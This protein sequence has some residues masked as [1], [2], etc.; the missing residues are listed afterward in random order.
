M[1][2]YTDGNIAVT[3][4]TGEIAA[5]TPVLA[6]IADGNEL[7]ITATGAAAVSEAKQLSQLKGAFAQTEVADDEYII[8]NDHFWN[9]SWLKQNNGDVKNV[10]VAPY[11]A[12]LTLTSTAG[13]K[14]N[15][16]SDDAAVTDRLV[17]LRP[18]TDLA[19]FLD[20]AE[21]YD[22]Q[23]RRLTA[24]KSGVMIVRKGGVSRKVVIKG[25]QAPQGL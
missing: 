11:R 2:S 10:F 19:A 20:G 4:L 17:S 16:I 21:L 22:L 9:A 25:S 15:S 1:G 3:A 8:A 24:P 13:A 14:P 18:G 7:S 23:G 12:S 5:G 6:Y